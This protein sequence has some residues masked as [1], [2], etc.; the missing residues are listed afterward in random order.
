MRFHRYKLF[1]E[2]RPAGLI[3]MTSLAALR[4]PHRGIN[5]SAALIAGF[6]V[7]LIVI[8]I[9]PSHASGNFGGLGEPLFILCDA[10]DD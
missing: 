6:K 8:L 2:R 7:M 4:G 9:V 1:S 3:Q 10:H 5:H